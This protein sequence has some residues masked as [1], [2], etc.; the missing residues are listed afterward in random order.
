M[1]KLSDL[2]SLYSLH[3]FVFTNCTITQ[4]ITA[5]KK[6]SIS[7]ESSLNKL[8]NGRLYFIVWYMARK[9]LPVM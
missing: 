9:L 5:R 6:Y 4:T 8:S 2:Y 7:M 3:G 1:H